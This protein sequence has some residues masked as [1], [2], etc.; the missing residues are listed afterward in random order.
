MKKALLPLMIAAVVS[1]AAHADVTVYGKANVSVQNADESLDNMGSADINYSQLEVVSNA[2]RIGL[3]GSEEISSGLKAIY[4]FEYQTEVDDGAGGSANQTFMQRNIY[5]GLQGSGGTV[6]GGMF[7][8][9]TKTAQEKVDLFND[10]E[11]DIN[12]VVVGETRAKNIVQYTTPASFGA[13]A[14]NVAAVAAEKDAVDD[15]YSASFTYTT[16]ALYAAIATETDVSAAGMDIIRLVGRYTVG[17]F[18]IGALYEKA[19]LSEG[20]ADVDSSSVLVS[21]KFNA[22]DKIALKAQYGDAGSDYS[23]PG[24]KVSDALSSDTLSL[25]VDYLLSKNTTVFG[26]YTKE[27]GEVK[28]EY[29]VDSNWVGVG[30]ELKF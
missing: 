4:Q 17:Q 23:E 18:Q 6:M 3:K 9:P 25:G 20:A 27:T 14:V 24:V 7:D 26:Y 30:L 11:G 21:V 22:T 10:L 29:S 19:S 5:V 28:E 1:A 12:W 2:S 16:P 15:G 13:F 8:T